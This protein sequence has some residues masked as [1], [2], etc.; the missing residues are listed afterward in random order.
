MVLASGFWHPPLAR[1]DITGIHYRL[2]APLP[3]ADTDELSRKAPLTLVGYP[4]FPVA[5]SKHTE[6]R[7]RVSPWPW[8][9]CAIL[10]PNRGVAQVYRMGRYRLISKVLTCM[11]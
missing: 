2:A 8:Q 7:R 10:P 1:V 11:R 6:A 4:T 9:E 3:G 5:H